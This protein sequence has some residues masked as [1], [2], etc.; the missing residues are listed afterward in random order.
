M[1]IRLEKEVHESP[2][3]VIGYRMIQKWF[4][5][6]IFLCAG[7]SLNAAQSPAFHATVVIDDTF[8]TAQVLP[9]AFSTSARTSYRQVLS[10]R[11]GVS[12]SKNTALRHWYSLSLQNNT[13]TT[14]HLY[15]N[16]PLVIPRPATI[17]LLDNRDRMLDVISYEHGDY[18]LVSQL[19]TGLVLPV[20]VAPSSSLK[21]LLGISGDKPGYFPLQVHTS[22]SYDRYS[23]PRLLVTG[24]I[25][26]ALLLLTVYFFLSYIYQKTTARFWLASVGLLLL[27]LAASTLE[28]VGRI[29]Q[30]INYGTTI[31]TVLMTV[32][33]LCLAKFTHALFPRIPVWL[34]WPNLLLC[35][36]PVVLLASPG[37]LPDTIFLL[38]I[39]PCFALL[40]TLLSALFKDRRNRSLNRLLA[41]GWL[42]LSLS[43]ALFLGSYNPRLVMLISS[44]L[45]AAVSLLV[46]MCTFALCVLLA[47]RD[48]SRQQIHTHERT[49][50]SLNVFYD[51]FRNAAEGLYTSTLDGDLRSVNPAM[52]NL[53]GYADESTM[54]RE[55]PNTR[56]F[57]ADEND[58]DLLVGELLEQK[59]IMGREMKGIKADGSEFWF[60]ISC[61]L[62]QENGETFMSGSIFDIT[63][64]KLSD[65]SLTYMA[66]H[67][68]LTGVFNRREFEHSLQVALEQPHYHNP[69]IVLYLDLD[70]FK[71]V[72]DSCGHKAGD[73]L[74]KELAE[75]LASKISDRGMLG[76]LGGDEFGVLLTTQTEESAYLLAIK[77]L[78]VV[79]NYRFFWEQRIFT[80]G[81]SIGL[82]NA[83]THKTDAE[84]ALNMADAACYLAKQQG[85]NQVYCYE[86]DDA[87]LQAYERE[88]TWVALIQQALNEDHG[89]VLY[90]QHYMPLNTTMQGDFYEI[91]LRLP[92]PNGKLA[93]PADFLPT[94][95]RYNLTPR[96]DRW[97]TEHTFKWL[98]EHPERLAKLNCCNININGFS[99]ADKDLRR[100]L[101]NAFQQHAIP[102]QKICFE[103]SENTATIKKEEAVSFIETFDKH[104]CLFAID[105][106]GSG[107]SSYGYF[108]SL[109]IHSVKIDRTFTRSLL[110]DAVDMAIVTAIRDIARARQIQTIAECVEDKATMTQLGKLGIDFAQGNA[111]AAPAP[112]DQFKSLGDNA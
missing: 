104:G 68:P 15:L 76:R 5:A 85:R 100:F 72:N 99:L 89:F 103:I 66:S 11:P 105:N 9:E 47:E 60:S 6:L 59:V 55:V 34:R 93:E 75:L 26:G 81:V 58:R 1:R 56:K 71:V 82:L 79:H 20:T 64:R 30:L 108:K 39:L 42:M 94:A 14:Q 111:I 112:L 107:F 95:E 36:T 38:Q 109:P 49:I 17:Y 62:H 86:K 33:L 22:A 92:L 31:M 63:R 37:L 83:T 69:V 2:A 48:M 3:V 12:Q 19:T 110:G 32:L 65:I 8:S 96:I 80:V 40:Q 54:L 46:A 4:L 106:F 41:L 52:C 44:E 35:L 53:F 50:D 73:R 57:Y 90:Y 10:G 29:L 43:Y 74:I 102:H 45:N 23:Q 97:V 88:R 98:S 78:D 70:R 16:N 84:N 21:V 67:D 51:L 91:L 24:I 101:L 18:D 25:C 13:A 27:L 87:S 61:Q 7:F 77:L 28:P